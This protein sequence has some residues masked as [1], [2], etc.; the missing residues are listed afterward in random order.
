[1]ISWGLCGRAAIHQEIVNAMPDAHSLS[2]SAGAAPI[3]MRI[4]PVE[5]PWKWIQ[6]G[7]RDIQQAPVVSLTY[8]AVFASVALM[9]GLGLMLIDWQAFILALS[10]GFLLLGPIFATGLYDV[11]RRL[12]RNEVVSLGDAAQKM[13]SARSQIWLFGILLLLA[14]IVWIQLAFFLFMLFL[15]TG[16]P[17]P[18]AGFLSTLLLTPSGLGLLVFGS[19]FGAVIAAIIFSISVIS[20]PLLQV[21]DVDIVTA[22]LASL[23]VCRRNP[24]AMLL[25]AALIAAIMSVGILT[26]FVGLIVAFPLV[27][28]ASWHAFMD[29]IEFEDTAA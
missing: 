13:F 20:V 9:L 7:W 4:V 24:K 27:G 25:W 12:E 6:A 23:E 10:G 21:R 28:H 3:A 16:S 15:G 17:P 1:M 19:L 26:F 2:R 18:I 5:Q 8:G 14:F 22:A 11:S 29:L